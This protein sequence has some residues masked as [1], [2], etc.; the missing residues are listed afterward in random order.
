MIFINRLRVYFVLSIT[1]HSPRAQ[2]D[3]VIKLTVCVCVKTVY[4]GAHTRNVELQL[5]SCTL[6]AY[7]DS[8]MT[9]LW[10]GQLANHSQLVKRSKT[11]GCFLPLGLF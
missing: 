5:G 3:G 10:D 8:K 7:T 1:Q 11:I 2:C 4:P 6:D 9:V